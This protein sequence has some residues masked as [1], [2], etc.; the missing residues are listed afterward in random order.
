MKTVLIS[1]GS[2]GIGRSTVKHFLEKSDTWKVISFARRGD[3]LEELSEELSEDQ[4]KRFAHCT[5][6]LENPNFTE[7]VQIIIEFAESRIDTLINN[8]GFLVVKP[9]EELTREDI[10]RSYQINV[11]SVFELVQVVLP[12]M[13]SGCIL[14]ISTMGGIRGAQKFPGLSAYSSS[15]S[16][17]LNLTELL[18]EEFKGR[19]IHVNAIALGAVKTPMLA[20]AFPGF[21]TDITPERI[22]E[23]IFHFTTEDYKLLNGKIIE[24]TATTP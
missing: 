8:A 17:L 6:D 16:A 3:S 23:Y 11:L 2:S 12:Y 10:R 7:L 14:N 9:F 22:A 13:S 21:E 4:R 24:L 19:G 1:G 5:L 18:A 15:K 20:S